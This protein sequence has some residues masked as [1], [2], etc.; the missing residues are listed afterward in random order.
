MLWPGQRGRRQQAQSVRA[1]GQTQQTW[2]C[3]AGE[4]N[5][6]TALTGLGWWHQH[7]E[8]RYVASFVHSWTK[9]SAERVKCSNTGLQYSQQWHLP[10]PKIPVGIWVTQ[11]MSTLCNNCIKSC[12]GA[13]L[14]TLSLTRCL[15]NANV[16]LFL[17][18]KDWSYRLFFFF[19]NSSSSWEMC[20]IL[21]A[22]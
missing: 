9:N 14:W 20:N 15:Q 7:R 10:F 8:G 16:S 22:S 18:Q 17:T 6:G 21:P 5:L 19:F 3:E 4:R 13:Q 12:W 11:N 1:S 2:G